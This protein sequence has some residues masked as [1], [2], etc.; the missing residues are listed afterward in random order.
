MPRVKHYFEEGQY[1]HITTRTERAAFLLAP[2]AAKSIILSS[3]RAYE[4]KGFFRLLA[5]V[6]MDNHLHFV[7]SVLNADGLAAALGRMKGWTSAQVQATT[8]CRGPV[9]E[10]RFDDN[11]IQSEQELRQVID[12]LHHNP[13]RVGLVKQ[14]T[15]YPWSSARKWAAEGPPLRA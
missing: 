14:A 12:Y 10:R 7:I 13:V 3:L 15:D 8:G 6:V 4:Q 9:W 2:D 5:Y 1:V 11:V